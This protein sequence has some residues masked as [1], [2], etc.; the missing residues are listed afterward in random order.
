MIPMVSVPDE[1][2]ATARLLDEV[3]GE[4]A[5]EGL[6]HSRPPLGIM[7][8]VPAVGI[9]PDLYDAD[10]Y[11]I[12]S[13]DLVQYTM[14]AGRDVAALADIARRGRPAGAAPDRQC[15]GSRS[16]HEPQGVAVR[17]RRRRPGARPASARRRACGLCPW[18]PRRSDRRNAPSRR[19]P[20]RPLRDASSPIGGARCRRDAG[21]RSLQGH[22]AGG[23][24]A[25]A[26]RH[27]PA[28]RPGAGQ[29]A[30]LHHPD[31]Q[32]G[33]CGPDPRTASLD[34]LRGLP[35]LGRGAAAVPRRL[36]AGPSAPARGR[37]GRP[38]PPHDPSRR[39][40]PRRRATQSASSSKWSRILRRALPDLPA[41]SA[42][43]PERT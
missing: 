35:F 17:R 25:P 18:H 30:E 29:G 13:N 20:S 31:H 22:P 1:I 37:G 24:G 27:A 2:A 10:F 3:C 34:H 42:C 36:H 21:H 40:R 15:G 26:V 5:R 38:A 16:P 4:L 7:V 28:A 14:A 33:L 43:P 12:G 32:S 11:S 8:E 39:A 9:A 23:P 19:I 6:P 41:R